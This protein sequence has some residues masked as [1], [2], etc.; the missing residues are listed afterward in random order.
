[1]GQRPPCGHDARVEIETSRLHLRPFTSADLDVIHAVYADPEVMRYV[2]NGAHRT[3]ADTKAALRTYADALAARGFS[4]VAVVERA[5][6]EVIGDA[7]LHPLAGRGP[8][9][10]LGYT[11]ARRAW[12]HGYATE[13]GR[14]LLRHAFDALHAPRVVA[15][16]E[17]DNAASRHVVEKLGMTVRGQ[18][19]AYGRPHLLYAVER[20]DAASEPPED[21]PRE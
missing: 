8:E 6:G 17:P 18:R 4:F 3:M 1:M 9:I 2:G 20:E 5:S 15:Q 13:L 16:V 7:G 21:A 11:L 12:G 14:A 19:T 10:E